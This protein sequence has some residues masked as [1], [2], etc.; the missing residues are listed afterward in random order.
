MQLQTQLELASHS[1]QPGRWSCPHSSAGTLQAP[2]TGQ[3]HLQTR[4]LDVLPCLTPSSK[5]LDSAERHQYQ[6]IDGNST[7]D[8]KCHM[9]NSV[10]SN[11]TKIVS[12]EITTGMG[13]LVSEPW[14]ARLVE[15]STGIPAT[16]PAMG[17]GTTI[18]AQQRGRRHQVEAG[19]WRK[20]LIVHKSGA[21]IDSAADSYAPRSTLQAGRGRANEHTPG[22]VLGRS[23]SVDQPQKEAAHSNPKQALYL[24]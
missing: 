21:R 15:N 3:Q 14:R 13:S 2:P 6:R 19:C 10:T 8:Q 1:A 23:H 24:V 5:V 18:A 17:M 22:G 11:V 16:R 9:T 7:G 20:P 4:A 12:V